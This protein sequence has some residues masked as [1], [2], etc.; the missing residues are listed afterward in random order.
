MS[1]DNY[2]KSM[3]IAR[4]PS[5]QPEYF[6]GLNW[7]EALP[8]VGKVVEFSNDGDYWYGKHKLE[9]IITS[10]GQDKRFV[11]NCGSSNPFFEYIRTCPETYAHP[12]IN[13]GGV[14]L[15]RPEVEAPEEGTE[16]WFRSIGNQKRCSTWSGVSLDFDRLEA[17]AVHLTEDRAQAWVD[18]WENTVIQQ[19][20]SQR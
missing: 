6:S 14:E 9:K 12:T 7:R 11:R 19:L 17:G 5:F 4:E 15:P 3:E 10:K 16:Y 20:R 13:F 18:W 1:R 8:L 2:L